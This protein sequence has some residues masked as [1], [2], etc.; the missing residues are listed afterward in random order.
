MKVEE[1]L[2]GQVAPETFASEIFPHDPPGIRA[3]RLRK[4]VVD[5]DDHISPEVVPYMQ[6]CVEEADRIA[7]EMAECN[8]RARELEQSGRIDDAVELYM[9]NVRHRFDGNMP[10]ERLRV[11]FNRQKR[12]EDALQVC[13][14][15]ISMADRLLRLGSPRQDL[16]TKREHFAEWSK[17]LQG[18]LD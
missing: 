9:Q 11:I 15:F 8:R 12:Y 18:R 2:K 5:L 6:A 10:Y 7:D 3:F 1:L 13:R 4:W 16:E 14:A 17:K